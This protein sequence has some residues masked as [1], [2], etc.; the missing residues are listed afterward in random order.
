MVADLNENG[1][2][3]LVGTRCAYIE[4]L[5]KMD[6]YYIN[7]KSDACP[8]GFSDEEAIIAAFKAVKLG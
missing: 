5:G 3:A 4:K 1:H 8:D 7:N 6:N 2:V